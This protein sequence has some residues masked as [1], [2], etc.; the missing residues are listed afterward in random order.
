MNIRASHLHRRCN[1]FTLVELLVV[2][3]II[4]ILI[5]ILL[6]S[7]SKARQSA[8]QISCQ[9]NMRQIGLAFVQYTHAYGRYPN[10]RWPEAL[11]SFLGGTLL[12]SASLP[13]DGT[14]ANVDK[15]SPLPLIHCPNVPETDGKNRKVTLTYCMNGI[16]FNAN[17][18]AMLCIGG[19]NN[20]NLLPRVRPVQIL[21]P[22]E[23][24]LMT[25]SWKTDNTEQCAWTTTWWRLFV[26]NGFTCIF[27]HGKSTNILFADG[28]VEALAYNPG[29]YPSAF[30]ID[31]YT[32]FP[33]LTDQN[34]S[35]F[36]YDYGIKRYGKLTRS[37]Y[38]P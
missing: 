15:V 30:S 17:W 37:R 18:W 31:A 26:G 12:G 10:F 1:G 7:L 32:G 4:A 14:N 20:D 22:D 6:P 24:G 27:T 9:N 25:E 21:H 13:D 35:L 28:H 11:N 33:T 3:G 5:S 19:Q 38:L 36:N 2:I 29:V 23:F 8:V 16:N 34:D